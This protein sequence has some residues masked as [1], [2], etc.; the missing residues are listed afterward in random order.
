MVGGDKVLPWKEWGVL[1]YPGSGD[2]ERWGE[3]GRWAEEGVQARG[4]GGMLLV[5]LRR[6]T[7]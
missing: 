4:E 7:L 2:G 3:G 6:P 5:D 1:G